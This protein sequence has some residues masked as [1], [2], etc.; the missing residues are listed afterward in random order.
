MEE[1]APHTD[2]D[3]VA[4]ANKAAVLASLREFIPQEMGREVGLKA[5]YLRQTFGDAI[6]SGRIGFGKDTAPG[7]IV[8]VSVATL[9]ELCQ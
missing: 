8:F 9:H 4:G 5:A 1:G 3:S 2:S 7:A 6:C